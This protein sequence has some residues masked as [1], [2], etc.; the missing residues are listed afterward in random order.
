[1]RYRIEISTDSF[2]EAV[3]LATYFYGY[4]DCKLVAEKGEATFGG[5]LYEEGDPVYGVSLYAAD[6]EQAAAVLNK[7]Q[8]F[9]F[10]IKEAPASAPIYIEEKV[11]VE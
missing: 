1:M 8:R 10:Y 2:M 11:W 5:R 4:E 9:C 7:A 3:G 6:E